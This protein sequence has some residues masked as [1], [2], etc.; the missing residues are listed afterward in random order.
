[1]KMRC[2]EGVAVGIVSDE[3]TAIH[4]YGGRFWELRRLYDGTPPSDFPKWFAKFGLKPEDSPAA[5]VRELIQS[6]I[7]AKLESLHEY[8]RSKSLCKAEYV[9]YIIDI[10]T[11][12]E[13]RWWWLYKAPHPCS[14]CMAELSS[15]RERLIQP[16]IGVYQ[17]DS[18]GLR[19]DDFIQRLRSTKAPVVKSNGRV[20]HFN[21]LDLIKAGEKGL[22]S[23]EEYQKA[24][25]ALIQKFDPG[26]TSRF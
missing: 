6:K 11:L 18:N 14:R 26:Y 16:T 17:G 23:S 24:E 2:I 21:L 9:R 12:A 8:E 25:T 19:D 15:R 22:V 7:S 3:D 10:P 1:M 20:S 4:V 5:P 13:N